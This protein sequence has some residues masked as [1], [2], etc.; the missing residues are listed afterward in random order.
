MD[1]KRVGGGGSVEAAGAKKRAHGA[2]GGGVKKDAG[3]RD[4]DG[5][6]GGC[7]GEVGRRDAD[8]AIVG[9][10]HPD[11]S[12]RVH[13]AV[14]GDDPKFG[15]GGPR[16]EALGQMLRRGAEKRE[17]G[18]E[19]GAEQPGASETFGGLAVGVGRGE[20]DDPAEIGGEDG[21]GAGCSAEPGAH[22]NAAHRVRDEVK[23]RRRGGDVRGELGGQPVARQRFEQHRAGGVREVDDVKTVAGERA[24]EATVSISERARVG[25]SACGQAGLRGQAG[26]QVTM[27]SFDGRGGS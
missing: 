9:F 6:M 4:R 7:A 1:D 25:M 24:A 8:R 14:A 18:S 19:Q 16:A 27:L 5:A 15:G 10:G 11:R 20:H 3:V 13:G 21:A 23:A 12:Q 2:S 17:I 26:G 22:E